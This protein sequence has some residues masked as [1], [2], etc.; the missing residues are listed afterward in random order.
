MPGRG[1]I[2]KTQ[3]PVIVTQHSPGSG[4]GIIQILMMESC[5]GQLFRF[6]VITRKKIGVLN[7][8]LVDEIHLFAGSGYQ[9]NIQHGTI[10]YLNW[11]CVFSFDL[12]RGKTEC[13]D[14][15]NNSNLFHDD[16][17]GDR[18]HVQYY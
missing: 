9:G 16:V 2:I 13:A 15:G 12:R 10:F 4:K 14:G 3:S 8:A 6:V 7:P 17:S 18:F 1:L 11:W 5:I